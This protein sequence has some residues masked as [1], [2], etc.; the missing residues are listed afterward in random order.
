MEEKR[1][2]W[3]YEEKKVDISINTPEELERWLNQETKYY[4][5]CNA[6]FY[7]NCVVLVTEKAGKEQLYYVDFYKGKFPPYY[8]AEEL[9]QLD[10]SKLAK[11][12]A[13][14]K[15]DW[16]WTT[17]SPD[18]FPLQVKECIYPQAPQTPVIPW[19]WNAPNA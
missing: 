17:V 13:K 5:Q 11:E 8:T 7:A 12:P 16:E 6:G 2:P 10:M 19:L 18:D 15:W 9:S 1:F 3:S 4:L 14:I